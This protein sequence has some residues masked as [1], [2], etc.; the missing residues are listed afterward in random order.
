MQPMHI[1]SLLLH[2]H[3]SLLSLIL[4]H[5]PNFS[6]SLGIIWIPWKT[7]KP[8]EKYQHSPSKKFQSTRKTSFSTTQKSLNHHEK[9]S[10][11]TLENFSISPKTLNPL[12]KIFNSLEVTSR[13]PPPPWENLKSPLQKQFKTLPKKSHPPPR[14]FF[15]PPPKISQPWKFL[16]LLPENLLTPPPENF[17][18]HLRKSLNLENFSTSSPKIF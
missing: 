3:L 18:T 8:L 11:P 5:L 6:N 7:L 17:S 2:P 1:I 16:N 14:K 4:P 12:W 15:N 13:T 10:T 9:A